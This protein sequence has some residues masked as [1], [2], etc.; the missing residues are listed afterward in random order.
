MDAHPPLPPEIWAHTPPAA[1]EMIVA[2]AAALA[3][4]RAVVAQ[5]KA[6]IE[7]LA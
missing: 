1:Q 7:E 3:Q 6:T 5:L 4:L 2:Q